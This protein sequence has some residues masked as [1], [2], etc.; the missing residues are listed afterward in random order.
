MYLTT[1]KCFTIRNVAT[2]LLD[3]LHQGFTRSSILRGSELSRVRLATQIELISESSFMAVGTLDFNNIGSSELSNDLA[4]LKLLPDESLFSLT[5][6]HHLFWGH[7]LA[8]QTNLL[9]FGVEKGGRHAAA[10][11]TQRHVPDSIPTL[12]ATAIQLLRCPCC[13]VVRYPL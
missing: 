5:S 7:G 10:G 8:K 12:R 13:N 2:L 9:M 3:D 6:R 4:L 11:R 1:L